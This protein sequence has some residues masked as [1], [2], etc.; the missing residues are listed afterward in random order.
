MQNLKVSR[1]PL[2][3]AR[4]EKAAKAKLNSRT[5][6]KRTVTRTSLAQFFR[7][8]VAI[9][10]F[11]AKLADCIVTCA[12]YI[13]HEIADTVGIHRIAELRLGGDF[14]SLGDCNLAHVVVKAGKFCT[15]PVGPRT[16]DAHPCRD[17]ILYFLIRPVA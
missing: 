17:A 10:V 14:V 2:E 7:E 9:L 1:E 13:L 8:S 5:V 11:H 3:I 12:I 6:A 16:N 15:L 4:L